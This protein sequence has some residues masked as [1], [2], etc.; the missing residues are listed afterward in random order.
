MIKQ[1]KSHMLEEVTQRGKR[2]K[3]AF[4][5]LIKTSKHAGQS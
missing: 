5:F 4:L 2:E 1:T 3:E